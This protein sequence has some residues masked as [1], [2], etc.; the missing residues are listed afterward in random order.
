MSVAPVRSTKYVKVNAST[1]ENVP[2][3]YVVPQ[4]NADSF[5]KNFHKQEHKIN[6]LTNTLFF[7]SIFAGVI[8]MMFATRNI[9]NSFI[10]FTLNAAGGVALGLGSFVLCG[11]YALKEQVKLEN[12]YGAVKING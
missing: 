10:R 1:N 12:K 9:K 5:R 3:Y 6:I 8:G 2:R 11:K 4:Q 7:S